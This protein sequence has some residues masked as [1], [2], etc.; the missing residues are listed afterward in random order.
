MLAR[1]SRRVEFWPNFGHKRG[2]AKWQ[3]EERQRDAAK[4][5]PKRRRKRR[6]AADAADAGQLAAQD[7][8]A[9]PGQTVTH[10]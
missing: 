4:S 9:K 2:R 8:E 7:R 1:Q 10:G 6:A 3:H 5:R